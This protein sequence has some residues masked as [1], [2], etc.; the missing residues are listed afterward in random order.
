L[1]EPGRSLVVNNGF[2]VSEVVLVSRKTYT[3]LDR[4]VYLD[5][6]KFNGLFETLNETT[7]YPIVTSKDG[8]DNE[9]A[10]A[11]LA[12]PTCDSM[13]TLY[14]HYKYVLPANLKAGD[15]VYFLSAGAY[16]ASFASVGFNGFPPIETYAM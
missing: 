4:W 5:A 3:D 16:T 10:E 1:L 15:R 8:P 14:E 7:K 2:V 11:I 9:T 6:G 13:D 12:G